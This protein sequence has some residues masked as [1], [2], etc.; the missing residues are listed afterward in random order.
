MLAKV[1]KEYMLM[2][3]SAK[4]S[5]LWKPPA[6]TA[7]KKSPGDSDGEQHLRDL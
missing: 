7:L 5:D 2:E 3:G 4:M 1:V 6:L